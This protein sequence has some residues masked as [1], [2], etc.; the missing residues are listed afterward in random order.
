MAERPEAT[1]HRRDLVAALLAKRGDALVVAGLG[2]A[3][4]DCAAV[5][6]N[7][8]DFPLWGAMG[9]AAMIG[10]GL[11]IA[12]PERRVLVITGD[13]DMAMG[14][15]GLATIAT[16]RPTNFALLVLDNER[17]GE[18]GMQKSHTAEGLDIAG[19]AANCRIGETLSVRDQAGWEAAMPLLL[20]APGPVAVIAKI[21]AE[22][23]PRVLP[24]R[25]GAFLKDRFRNAL[26]GEEAAQA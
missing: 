12:Q 17:H 24:P 8:L 18:T 10:L 20:E 16:Q 4:W 22:T 26:L 23:L 6:N 5:E 1:L 7:P 21:K 2:S 15:G 14:L 25:D 11:S 9:N 3:A 13:G 19:V